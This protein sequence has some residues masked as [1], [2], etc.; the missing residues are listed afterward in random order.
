[1]IDPIELTRQLVEIPSPTGEEHR[2]TAFLAERLEQSGWHVVRQPVVNG[3]EN[4]YAVRGDPVVVFSTHL[5]TVPPGVPLREDDANLHGR[6]TCDAK[7]IAAAMIAAA[8]TLVGEGENRIGLLFLVGEENGSEGAAAAARLEP[9]GRFLING[10]PTE[11]RLCIAQ[12]GALRVTL[13]ASGRAA[14]SG[15]PE[16]G[17]SAVDRLLGALERIRR[18]PLPV[19][20]VLGP[21]TL[22]VGVIEGGA[23]PNVLAPSARAELLI[24]L[25]GPSDGLRR[26]LVEAAGTDVEIAFPLEMP[27]YQMPPLD[28]WPVATVAFASDL[29]F[30]TS[31]GVGYQLGPGSIHVAH[32]ADEYIAKADLLEG[33]A[34]YVRLARQLLAGAPR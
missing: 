26:Q 2:V 25:V 20:P 23:A 24:R 21:S 34:L 3:R 28:G 13:K 11:N 8:E 16:L 10:E 12:K 9:R 5:D 30:L 19:D 29:P 1:M 31:W 14:H 18:L 33:V 7:G 27:A 4:I 32:T 15:Y 17:I 6:G 22:N